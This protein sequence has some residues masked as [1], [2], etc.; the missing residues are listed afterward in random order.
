LVARPATIAQFARLLTLL[1]VPGREAGSIASASADWIDSDADPVPGGAED[2]AYASAKPAYRTANT[3]MA[4][5]SEWRM[6]AGV[7]PAIYSRVRPFVCALPVTEP[8]AIN[9][10]TLDLLQAPLLAMLVPTLDGARA[11]AALD[12]R[13]QS[14]WETLT[15]FWSLPELSGSPPTDTARSQ[16]RLTTR[17]FDVALTIELADAELE[18]HV[19]IDAQTKPAKIARR[20]F[21]EPS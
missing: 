2:A 7:T 16:V 3:M 10:N 4:D 8:T 17:W 14:G 13:P 1:E 19:L 9:V 11:R 21:G 6:V 5:T 20:S 15:T 18:D 12:K